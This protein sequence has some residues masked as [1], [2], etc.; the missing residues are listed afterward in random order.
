MFTIP[1]DF[2]KDAMGFSHMDLHKFMYRDLPIQFTYF[3]GYTMNIHINISYHAIGLNHMVL[4]TLM[5]YD[6]PLQFSFY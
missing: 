2:T 1:T 5:Y 4:Q 3:H 6:L